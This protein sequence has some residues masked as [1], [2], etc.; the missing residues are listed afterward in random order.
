MERGEGDASGFPEPG[1]GVEGARFL[2]EHGVVAVGADTWALEVIPFEREGEQFPVHQELLAKS[3]TYVLENMDTAELAVDNAT[4][5]MF[6]LGVPRFEGAV[7]MI[8]NPVAI[9]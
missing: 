9:R 3:G 1:I 8:V 2:V 5:F 6:V 4:E 7:Q